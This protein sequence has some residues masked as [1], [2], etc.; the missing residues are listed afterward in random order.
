MHV[1]NLRDQNNYFVQIRTLKR[2]L[3]HGIKTEDF[4]E[5]IADDVEKGFVIS[6]V[7]STDHCLQEK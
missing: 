1:C 5:V 6:N 7:Q 2:A 4:Y 3:D